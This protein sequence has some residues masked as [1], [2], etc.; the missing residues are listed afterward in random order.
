LHAVPQLPHE[1]LQEAIPG[2][3]RRAEH[4]ITFMKKVRSH[5]ENLV[6]C[7]AWRIPGCLHLVD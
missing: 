1:L 2:N 4:F 5:D 6:C 3:I 7:W